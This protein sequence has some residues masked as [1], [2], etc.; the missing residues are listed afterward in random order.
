MKGSGDEMAKKDGSEDLRIKR[1][2]RAIKD[3]FYSLVEEKGFEHITVKDITERAMISRNTFYLHYTD[4]YDLL[5]RQ[6]DDLMRTL[7]FKVGKQLR[8]VKRTDFTVDGIAGIISQGIKVVDEDKECYRILLGDVSA[9]IL[10][11]KMTNIVRRSIDY[12]KKD[13]AK[14]SD[15]QMEYIVCGITGL[16]KY[17]VTHQVDDIDEECKTFTALN[18]YKLIELGEKIRNEK[19]KAYN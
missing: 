8:T 1:T 16:I 13:I 9:D 15:F 10:T 14:L 4:K 5:N 18:L 3:A 6:C 12:I 19:E 11:T 7:F 2:Q 17:Y